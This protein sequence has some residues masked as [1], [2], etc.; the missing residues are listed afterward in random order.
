MGVSA[1]MRALRSV[2]R[3]RRFS[4]DIDG[5]RTTWRNATPSARWAHS[6]I[7]SGSSGIGPSWSYRSIVAI[8]RGCCFF[9]GAS[10]LVLAAAMT[11]R[12]R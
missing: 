11:F 10:E 12:P 4:S 7:R 2:I 8:G 6:F 9:F 5:S 3:P 1:A